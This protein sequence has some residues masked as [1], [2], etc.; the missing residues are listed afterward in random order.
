MN[1][2]LKWNKNR[3]NVGV[4]VGE[5]WEVGGKQLE[6]SRSCLCSSI[7]REDHQWWHSPSCYRA[8]GPLLIGP[9]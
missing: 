3:G 6:L 2:L 9:G 8:S 5:G 7:E 1:D 4:C